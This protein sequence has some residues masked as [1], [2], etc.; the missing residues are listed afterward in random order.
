M[1]LA[2]QAAEKD[3]LAKDPDVQA[4]LDLLHTQI[5]AEAAS[6]KYV[7]SHPVSDDEVK[8]AYDSEVAN[9]PKEYKA[10]HILV[11]TKE[12][13]DADHQANC[14]LAATSRRSPRRSRRIRAARSRAATS[15]GSRRRRW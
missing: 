11:E 5:L 1:T 6:D 3:G 9:M 15:A 14:R 13:A 4:R 8:A 10:R 7:K 2:A 12:A